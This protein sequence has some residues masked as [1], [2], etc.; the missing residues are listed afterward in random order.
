VATKKNYLHHLISHL[1]HLISNHLHHLISHLTSNHLLLHR[2]DH[3]HMDLRHLR[4]R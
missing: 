1:H 4:M 2:R 3:H